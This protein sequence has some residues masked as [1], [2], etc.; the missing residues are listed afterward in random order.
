MKFRIDHK[1]ILISLVFLV[2]TFALLTSTSS[3]AAD[4]FDNSSLINTS[5][6]KKNTNGN[7]NKRGGKII[8][9]DFFRQREQ[10]SGL[11]LINGLYLTEGQLTELIP[12]A[13]ETSKLAEEVRAELYEINNE[14]EFT[15]ALNDHVDNLIL[16]NQ[17]DKD[18][19]I[20]L[21]KYHGREVELHQSLE[22]KKIELG[23]NVID[24]LTNEQLVLVAEF[25]P[26]LIA[27]QDENSTL[28][29]Q[30]A[31][32]HGIQNGLRKMRRIPQRIWDKRKDKYLDKLIQRN[33][34]HSPD[35][36]DVAKEKARI[37][38]IIKQAREY[39]DAE[40]EVHIQELSLQLLL[41]NP[42]NYHQKSIAR[43]V[44][45][46]I[47]NRDMED[48]YIAKLD[49]IQTEKRQLTASGE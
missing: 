24:I 18:L 34:R 37:D 9:E 27:P 7:I 48:V 35:F 16:G 46:L 8:L 40:F 28:T 49:M 4:E 38:S 39:S 26:C 22:N 3:K 47:L 41:D 42:A 11:N 19:R 36:L 12:L 29:G 25:K 31:G 45:N 5:K 14:T 43:K 13:R 10:I 44:G 6:I 30:A 23:L 32:G 2:G 21:N 20:R 1:T 15:N 33:E 17:P